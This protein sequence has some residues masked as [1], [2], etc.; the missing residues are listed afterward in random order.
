MGQP[1]GIKAL[2]EVASYLETNLGLVMTDPE[3][4]R[5]FIPEDLKVRGGSLPKMHSS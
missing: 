4:Q 1:Y 2:S 5:Y 3:G